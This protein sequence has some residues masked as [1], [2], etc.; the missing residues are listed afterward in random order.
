[1]ELSEGGAAGLDVVFLLLGGSA[2]LPSWLSSRL[3]PLLIFIS[4][5]VSRGLQGHSYA[6]LLS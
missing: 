1:M 5:L 4:V 6:E 2:G 3:Y